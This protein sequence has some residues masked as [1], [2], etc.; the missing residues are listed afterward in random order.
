MRYAEAG[1]RTPVLQE[2][3]LVAVAVLLWDIT[4]ACI[5]G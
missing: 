2:G 1:C 3:L 5:L 4:I